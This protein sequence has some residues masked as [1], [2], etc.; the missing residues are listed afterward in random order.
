MST[1]FPTKPS[2]KQIDFAKSIAKERGEELPETVLLDKK[3]CRAYLDKYASN[4]KKKES[5]PED[6]FPALPDTLQELPSDKQ[7]QLAKNIHNKLSDSIDEKELQNALP[8]KQACSKFIEKYKPSYSARIE[9][10]TIK[11]E[12]KRL[13]EFREALNSIDFITPELRTKV[14]AADTSES[15]RDVVRAYKNE[16]KSGHSRIDAS[17]LNSIPEKLI[18]YW[19]EGLQS[20]A[21]DSLSKLE[22]LLGDPKGGFEYS[23]IEAKLNEH[24][25]D[26][27]QF[28]QLQ[29]PI[30][31]LVLK[32]VKEKNREKDPQVI[33]V[34]PLMAI[35]DLDDPKGYRWQPTAERVPLFNRN[36][37]GE[38]AKCP[39]LMLS[40][41]E[42]F[43][44][45][46]SK[47]EEIALSDEQEPLNH[48]NFHDTL[49][50]WNE[51]FNILSE[52]VYRGIDG[53]IDRFY[54][55][56][57]EFWQIKKHRAIFTLVDGSAAVGTSK[58]VCNVYRQLLVEPETIDAQALS[59]FRRIADIFPSQK[60]SYEI[61]KQALDL[62]HLT[63][64]FGHMDSFK[65][66]KREAFPLD[67]AQRDALIALEMTPPGELLAVNGPPGTGKTSLLR[68]VIASVW[69]APLLSKAKM[70]ACPLILACAATNQ[71][72]TNIISSFD[73]TPGPSLFDSD[74]DVLSGQEVSIDSRWLPKLASY[75]WYAPPQISGKVLKDY[76]RYQ[77]IDRQGTYMPWRFK[78]I[79][80]GLDNL[81]ATLAESAY[82]NCAQRYFGIQL[83]LSTTI[84]RLRQ[85]VISDKKN[86]EN[87]QESIIDW[88]KAIADLMSTTPWTVVNEDQRQKLLKE[89]EY[90]AGK[91][92]RRKQLEDDVA[93]IDGKIN[94]FAKFNDFSAPLQ[95][96]TSLLA[97]LRDDNTTKNETDYLSIKQQYHDIGTL[98]IKLEELR[99]TSFL[100]RVKTAFSTI[101]QRIDIEQRW[102]ALREIML[103][104]RIHV[105]DGPPD[106][107][108]WLS[109][110]NVRR[111]EL[112]TRLDVAAAE[113]LRLYLS[114]HGVKLTPTSDFNTVW[115][116]ELDGYRDELRSTRSVLVLEMS[117]ID[118]R[119]ISIK[120]DLSSLEQVRQAYIAAIN[121]TH[122]MQNAVILT[123][124]LFGEE[125][126]SDSELIQSM[127][128]G[129]NVAQRGM[130]PQ[131]GLWQLIHDINRHAQDWLDINV[132]TR[133][134]HFTARY[135]EGRYIQS[136]K[137]SSECLQQDETYVMAS[138]EQLRELAMLA[139]VFVVTA[140][141]APKLMR[142]NLRDLDENAPPYLFGEADLLIVDE[143]GQGTAEIGANT[144]MFAQKAIVVGDVAQLEPV[145][146]MGESTDKCLVQ[147][148]G[149]AQLSAPNGTTPYQALQPS[150][151]LIAK[152][153]VMRMAQRA[154]L[155]SNPAFADTPGL[156]LTNH[157]RCLSPIIEICNRMVY[158]GALQVKTKEPKRLWRPELQRLGFLVADEISN[159]KNPSG[160][161]RN[162]AEAKCIAQW[163]FEN[164]A[165][166]VKHYS[167]KDVAKIENLLA[168]VTPFS[169][170]KLTLK[171]AL[172]K[173]Y[174]LKWDENDKSL[175]YNK[176]I[177][178][179]V[180][181][182]QGAER[183]IVIFAM[184]ETNDPTSPQFYD[185][186]TNLINVA[187]SRAKEMFIVTLTQKAVNYAR[188]LSIRNVSK[189]SD[190]LWQAVV[191]NGSRLNS[192]RLIV[193][194]SPNK[195]STVKEALGSSIEIEVIATEGH[196]AELEKP[197]NWNAMEAAQPQWSGLSEAGAKVFS[198]IET[199][200][201]DLE[202]CYLATD[203]DPEGEA[204]A[205]H[206][207]RILRDRK[208]S[209]DIT[210]PSSVAPV[211]K[212]MR[213]FN[214]SMEEIARAYDSASEGLDAGMVKSALTRALLD[215]LINT[216]YPK[217][218]GL[219]NSNGFTRGIGRV[220]LGVLDL[221]N[222]STQT[223]PTYVIKVAIPLKEGK[224]LV[225]Y[226][227]KPSAGDKVNVTDVWQTTKIETAE[228]AAL[229]IQEKL[230]QGT[231]D[232]FMQWTA[233]P[234]IQCEPYPGLN[235]ARL[236]ALA[237]RAKRLQPTQVMVSLQDL[238]EG[239][240]IIGQQNAM[241][242]DH[243]THT[244][245][246]EKIL[247]ASD[248]Q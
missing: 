51:A 112:R 215:Y 136:K 189:P 203:P 80:D 235:T 177:I 175:I 181:T 61:P 208:G 38:S 78:G 34:L 15:K 183:Q 137:E 52:P 150:G 5:T 28:D 185:K 106:I 163:I 211:I 240:T 239:V 9:L 116:M 234:M 210:T 246:V 157:Y 46:A 197:E 131:D 141:S 207:L 67:P 48:P 96:Y 2:D 126:R 225:T 230:N 241:R 228:T 148:F 82:L 174:K 231:K 62:A 71:A 41:V 248:E 145:W 83:D 121:H 113:G 58:Q 191:T 99:H 164:E 198:K 44:D 114:R 167:G 192:R 237:W 73:E 72:V 130:Q 226:A 14:A 172:Q 214:L 152:G 153:S 144:F 109:A 122:K 50:L 25:C 188:S 176:L 243:M 13:N 87:L 127:N 154:T 140:Y 27:I 37:M 77:L 115:P 105:A 171:K 138:D 190:Y 223:K 224:T 125:I 244:D 217:R 6:N 103:T 70:P 186:G 26:N 209:G 17:K 36:L 93:A 54:Q 97:T 129:F 123:M 135:W 159:T 155:W 63:R 42:H 65:D 142:R 57:S 20:T 147:R 79:V 213:F 117:S 179:T 18:A 180:H 204:I 69:V 22:N 84:H 45:W 194:E 49:E 92:G 111:A 119:L 165:S 220:Q 47:Q 94:A 3:A 206:V 101:F 64:Y 35:P 169:G 66:G 245:P 133:I 76:G 128:D 218:L 32:L 195:C 4:N 33:S 39:G 55:G 88:I 75:G 31:H 242:Q 81:T 60:E 212:R 216:E 202:A 200:W 56:R 74:G 100:Q 170:Q 143:A 108:E 187:I 98:A 193:V 16:S 139:P 229:R 95:M 30:R 1:N 182:L 162:E 29:M 160:S 12:Q 91:S 161:R 86:I 110:I 205:W 236:L 184:V 104:F 43:D 156:T 10:E 120:R 222:Q 11:R 221:V 89:K 19:L 233:Q 146:N 158:R 132:R 247:C 102:S 53:W 7:K 199:L 68:G 219:N 196:I 238:Y 227:M 178:D 232:F 168:I 166:I 149:V 134:F 173:Q 40:N 118:E 90:L 85:R 201:P 23:E 24:K 107:D 151:V 59:L 21:F 8:S 124:T